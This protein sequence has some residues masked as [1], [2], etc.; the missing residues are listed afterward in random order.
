MW[1]QWRPKLHILLAHLSLKRIAVYEE[2]TGLDH[3]RDFHPMLA[4]I[5]AAWSAFR[6]ALV[7]TIYECCL[8]AG[9]P[10]PRASDS[11][12]PLVTIAARRDFSKSS[13]QP[14]SHT[15]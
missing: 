13:A 6:K 10:P 1:I 9:E 2:Q 4:E 8:E 12:N 7:G 15:K 11:A 3:R 14:G 5:S